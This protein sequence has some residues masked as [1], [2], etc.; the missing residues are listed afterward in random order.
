MDK[1]RSRFFWEGIGNK[2]KYHMVDWATVCRPKEA[3][4]LGLLNTKMM[5]IALML[6]WI[7]RLYQNEE[8]LWVDLLKA[9][10]G[11]M[12]FSPL[13][14]KLRDLSYGTPL[15]AEVAF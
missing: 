11:I 4:G 6:R 14:L 5:N 13:W 9:K 7:W 3:G 12:I 8:G 2:R 1:S 10:Y 15:E